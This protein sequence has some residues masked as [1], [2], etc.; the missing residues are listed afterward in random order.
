MRSTARHVSLFILGLLLMAASATPVRAQLDLKGLQLAPAGASEDPY[1][2]SAEFTAATGDKPARLFI[3]TKISDGW[4]IYS[5]TQPPGGPV[6]TKLTV[7][8]SPD[9]KLGGEFKSHPAP[10]LHR[11]D[12]VFK[13]ID[14]EEHAGQVVWYAPLELAPGVDPAQLKVTGKVFLQ[15]C[16]SNNCIAP[17]SVKF[18]AAQGKGVDVGEKPSPEKQS[19]AAPQ[20][21]AEPAFAPPGS[22]I[23]I[24]GTVTPVSVKPGE[25]AKLTLLIKPNATWHLY[26]LAAEHTSKIAKPTLIAL[27]ETSGLTPSTVVATTRP[28][29]E[30]SKLD[31]KE[32]ET[33][34]EGEVAFTFDLAV[35]A[36]AKP[37]LH[38][39][40]GFVGYQTCSGSQCIPPKGVAFAVD[41]PVGVEGQAVV[42]FEPA[43]YADAARLVAARSTPA[44]AAAPAGFDKSAIVVSDSNEL[45]QTP[46][47]EAIGLAFVGGIILNL[48]PC[49]LPVIGLKIL[50]FVE[51]SGHHRSRIFMLNVWYTLGLMSVFLILASMAVFFGL[52]WGQQFGDVRFTVAL[53]AIV[54]AMGLSFLG[55]WEIPIPGFAGGAKASDLSRQ[56]GAGGAFFKGVITTILATPCSGP[57]MATALAWAVVQPP[58]LTYAV[59]A[60]IG[61]GMASPYLVIGAFPKLIR[62]LPKPGAWMD[63]FKQLMGFVLLAT[64]VYFLTF[65]PLSLVVPTVALLFGV[66]AACWW[67]G[68]TPS[69]EALSK[70]LS[71]WGVGMVIAVAAGVFAFTWLADVMDHRFN[72]TIEGEIGQRL[73]A[74]GTSGSS[75][76]PS[77]HSDSELPWQPFSSARLAELTQQNKTVMVDFTAD[78]CPNCKLNEA[79]V[80]NTTE[81][82]KKVDQ[83]EIV[84]LVAD[85]TN[86]SAEV[87]EMLDAL[88]TKL[89]PV[90]AIFPA[91]NPN[92][93]IVLRGVLTQEQLLKALAD[94]GPSKT[95]DTKA[96]TALQ[97]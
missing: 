83:N 56:E 73:A 95:D 71:A 36:D 37:G 1:A 50:S 11:D 13:G 77:S 82:R 12:V 64:V 80:L 86:G 97:R 28:H 15:A 20:P 32:I 90:T 96:V 49:V 46:I 85:W 42:R 51:Q 41:I 75:I 3:T 58:Y 40:K 23:T 72:R 19:Q 5:I 25:T 74:A 33:S 9:F 29:Q 91:G 2:V 43:K 45:A 34:Y 8:A 61:L 47:W 30:P 66:W 63:T 87:T 81:T 16:D 14:L 22:E 93:P 6:R 84:C 17:K 94:A 18:T 70:R 31:P 76:V 68:R 78:W 53:A 52:G 10:E 55:V 38:A 88:G 44:P 59:F 35:P 21:A 39:V 54:F 27:A 89:I 48:M 60:A 92:R 65:I 24:R 7:D 26:P 4:H 57:L 79:V 62:F 67:I 69:Y